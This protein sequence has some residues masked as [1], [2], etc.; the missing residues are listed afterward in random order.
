MCLSLCAQRKAAAGGRCGTAGGSPSGCTRSSRRTPPSRTTTRCGYRQVRVR[1]HTH[2]HTHTLTHTHT[3]R[4]QYSVVLSCREGGA[5]AGERDLPR[6]RHH[7]GRGLRGQAP[8]I[9]VSTRR[10][11]PP[12]TSTTTSPRTHVAL[13]YAKY[14]LHS[15]VTFF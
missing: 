11:D 14:T 2:T 8:A 7:V 13:Y 15:L 4:R 3:S 10:G 1:A 6:R 12:C 9:L 5:G